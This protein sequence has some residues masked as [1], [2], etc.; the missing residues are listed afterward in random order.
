VN[1]V[2]SNGNGSSPT[3][4]RSPDPVVTVDQPANLPPVSVRTTT[5]QVIPGLP[6]PTS[7]RNFRLQ[8]GAFPDLEAANQAADLVRRAGFNVETDFLGSVHRVMAV[9]IPAADV[10]SASN[11]LGALGFNQI[12]LRE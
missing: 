8:I 3:A 2:S 7:G 4:T 5:V 11:R 9:G 12:W 10:S 1:E 6:D